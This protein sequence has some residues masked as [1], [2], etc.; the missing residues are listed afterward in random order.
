MFPPLVGKGYGNM[1]IW[2]A[3]NSTWDLGPNLG[4]FSKKPCTVVS[5][6]GSKIYVKMEIKNA[7]ETHLWYVFHLATMTLEKL[8]DPPEELRMPSCDLIR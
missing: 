8:T 7:T 4:T 3:R 5:S 1:L 6:D 2:N